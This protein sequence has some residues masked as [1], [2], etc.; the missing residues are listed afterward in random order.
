M[1]TIKY[2]ELATS[3]DRSRYNLTSIYR[4]VDSM[5]ACDGYRLHIVG[6]LAPIDKPHLLD[7]NPSEYPNYRCCLPDTMNTIGY[8][9]FDK[10]QVKQIKALA[11][12]IRVKPIIKLTVA[13]SKLRLEYSTATVGG[14]IQFD[15]DQVDNFEPVG[16]NLEYLIDAIVPDQRITLKQGSS[17]HKAIIL[18]YD[19]YQTFG[20]IMPCKL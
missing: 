9:K 8:L 4:D 1:D 13:D 12:L 10:K 18:S 2:L 5:V 19:A 11:T 20:L 16:I 17:G 15:I 14:Y 6:G 7:G 3:K